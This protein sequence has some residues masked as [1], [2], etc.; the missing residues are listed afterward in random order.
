MKDAVQIAIMRSAVK[1]QLVS[2]PIQISRLHLHREQRL[3]T[4]EE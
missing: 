1:N 3:F 2:T 4:K